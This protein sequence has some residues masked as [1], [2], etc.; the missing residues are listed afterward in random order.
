MELL[1]AAAGAL[2]EPP[3]QQPAAEGQGPGGEGLHGRDRNLRPPVLE[4][5]RSAA[6]TGLFPGEQAAEPRR[7]AQVLLSPSG[8]IRVL[9]V[10]QHRPPRGARRGAGSVPK[11]DLSC[12]LSDKVPLKQMQRLQLPLFIAAQG[13]RFP[14]CRYILTAPRSTQAKGKE[15]RGGT[16]PAGCLL[17]QPR[18]P[19]GCTRW[20][21]LC[22]A[23]QG[24]RRQGAGG[25][26][27]PFAHQAL[28]HSTSGGAATN[29]TAPLL[30]Q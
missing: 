21:G 6:D 2:S 5:E 10:E 11:R 30:S 22:R 19:R 26:A 8:S 25:P 14:G 28:N 18:G 13:Q 17:A 23:L 29:V 24:G 20:A 12:A 27:G 3:A 9:S 4:E 7:L 16:P 15:R 1:I